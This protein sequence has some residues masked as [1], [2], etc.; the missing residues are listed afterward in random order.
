MS[1]DKL[2]AE[3]QEIKNLLTVIA[4]RTE[5]TSGAE[6]SV[7][8]LGWTREQAAMIRDQLANFEE[9]WNAPGMEVYDRL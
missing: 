8:A 6:K 1:D 9:D 4:A 5:P 3:L 2:L 7:A